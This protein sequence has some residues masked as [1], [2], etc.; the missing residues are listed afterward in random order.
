MRVCVIC[1]GQTEQEFVEQCLYPVLLTKGIYIFTDHLGGNVSAPRLAHFVR[2]NYQSYDV[3]TT[4]VDFY[5]FKNNQSNTRAELEAAIMQATQS[6]FDNVDP[7]QKFRPYVQMYEFEGL[8]FSDIHQFEWLLD[9]WVA[10][11]QQALQQIR[12]QF[13]TPEQ[14]NNSI[15]TKPSHRIEE[16][17][18]SYVKPTHGIILAQEIG[19]PRIRSECPNFNE[20]LTWLESLGQVRA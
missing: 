12:D 4:F 18:P 14:I 11:K 6:L 9:D 16:L 19:L 20:W 5:G 3:I 10:D 8:L 15:E 13:T 1:E 17:F 7:A 2:N